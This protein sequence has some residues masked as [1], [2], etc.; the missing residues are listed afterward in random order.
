MKLRNVLIAAALLA[1]AGQVQAQKISKIDFT[2]IS[3]AV[4]AP[5]SRYH[6]PKLFERYK[7][8]DTTLSKVDYK[9]LY[10]GQPVMPG[11]QPYVKNAKK[12]ELTTAIQQNDYNKAIA[13]S[14][15]ILAVKPFDLNTVFGMVAAYSQMKNDREARLWEYK[16]RHLADVV[17]DSGDGLTKETA[18]VVTDSGDEF[19]V[20][21][22]LGLDVVKQSV[23]DNKYDLLEIG[24]P[25]D[26]NIKQLYFNIEKP[27]GSLN[28]KTTAKK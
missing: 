5:K 3:E 23:V 15:E 7:R 17:F 19:I 14:K 13:L 18:Y 25:N 27:L 11:Y 21:G 8:N 28:K 24:Q 16:F 10:Y 12:K 4:K 9:Y 20:T 2:V 22:I 6:Y 26:Y 1:L